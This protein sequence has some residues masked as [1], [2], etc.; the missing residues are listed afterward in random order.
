MLLYLEIRENKL[1]GIAYENL[2]PDICDYV[3]A[4]DFAKISIREIWRKVFLFFN[5][6][7]FLIQYRAQREKRI[8]IN[9]LHTASG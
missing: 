9:S 7:I 1:L 4:L 2:N 8:S 6:S 5:R 3:L